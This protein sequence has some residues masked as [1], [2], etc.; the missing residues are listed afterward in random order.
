MNYKYFC[1]INDNIKNKTC[2]HINSRA[3]KDTN[4]VT[5]TIEGKK[6]D[7]TIEQIISLVCIYKTHYVANVKLLEKWPN[8]G[9]AQWIPVSI[10]FLNKT[11]M[12]SFRIWSKEEARRIDYEEWLSWYGDSKK[13]VKYKE[14]IGQISY[15]TMIKVGKMGSCIEMSLKLGLGYLM[16][17][18][19]WAD[20]EEDVLL[21]LIDG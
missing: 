13:Q 3:I 20:N 9:K 5:V 6:E 2:I 7:I 1:S 11:L 12:G 8:W 17:N 18:I 19:K 15:D 4:I 10:D 14:H 16:K 21:G